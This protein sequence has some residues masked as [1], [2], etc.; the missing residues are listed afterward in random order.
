MRDGDVAWGRRTGPMSL[1]CSSSQH[2]AA[3]AAAADGTG[4]NTNAV[5]CDDAIWWGGRGPVYCSSSWMELRHN[6]RVHGSWFWKQRETNKLINK[7]D[8]CRIRGKVC[9]KR[10]L[11]GERSRG[12]IPKNYLTSNIKND[13]RRTKS[14]FAIPIPGINMETL[15]L[16]YSPPEQTK[17]VFMDL[18]STCDCLNVSLCIIHRMASEE[19]VCSP[20]RPH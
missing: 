9:G 11:S 2:I 14:D 15:S 16:S 7:L 18:C 3:A 5:I 12:F 1:I 17:I 20:D 6:R 10:K 19:V 13:I 8:K 4:A